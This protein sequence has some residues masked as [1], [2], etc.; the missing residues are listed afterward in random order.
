MKACANESVHSLK[1]V[2]IK[3]NAPKITHSK[4]RD[5]IKAWVHKS[6]PKTT[7]ALLS[8]LIKHGLI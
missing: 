2:L 1:S 6:A 7:S 8:A 5:L 4:K 3:A